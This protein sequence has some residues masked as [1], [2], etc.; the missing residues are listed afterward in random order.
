MAKRNIAEEIA[1]R[2]GYKEQYATGPAIDTI[3]KAYQNDPKTRLA[4]TALGR[5][6]DT[7]PVAEGGWGYSDG[8]ARVL[9]GVAGGAMTNAQN[10]RYGQVQQ[11]ELKDR[12]AADAEAQANLAAAVKKGGIP[13]PPQPA[14]VHQPMQP[15][16]A[17]PV[18]PAQALPQ[19]GAMPPQAPQM[20]PQGNQVDAVATELM[21]GG[22]LPAPPQAGQGGMQMP[23]PPFPAKGRGGSASLFDL[24]PGR[25]ALEAGNGVNI[26]SDYRT[27]KENDALPNSVKNS[28]HTR[29]DPEHPQAYDFTPRKGESMRVLELRAKRA[30]PGW[31]V[32]NEGNHIHVEPSRAMEAALKASGAATDQA[33]NAGA[34]GTATMDTQGNAVPPPPES[35]PSDEGDMPGLPAPIARPN[36]PKPV[37]ARRSELLE[38]AR[39]LMRTR[40]PWSADRAAAMLES[41]LAEQGRFNESAAER[42]QRMA[43]GIYNKDFDMYSQS[44]MLGRGAIYDERSQRRGF[45]HDTSERLGGE[46]FQAGESALERAQR[47]RE[48]QLGFG[49]DRDMAGV[50]F[51]YDTKR[52][53]Q[54]FE[55][56]KILKMLELDGDGAKSF[57]DFIN[58][59]AGSKVYEQAGAD[60]KD[61]SQGL[62]LLK[63]WEDLSVNTGGVLAATAPNVAAWGSTKMQVARQITNAIALARSKD[64]KGSLSDNDIKFLE[65]MSPNIRNSNQANQ[66]QIDQLRTVFARQQEFAIQK[67]RARS[68]KD[69]TQF[70]ENWVEYT[71]TFPE[72]KKGV[73]SYREWMAN[74][75]KNVVAV[76]NEDGSIKQ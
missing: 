69:P 37:G 55:H 52:A 24:T 45:G 7:S 3:A 58:T 65:K 76:Y 4:V 5:G 6:A 50:N 25:R 16:P 62:G 39:A 56:Q 12:E 21:G 28:Y 22:G 9:S 46:K 51:G 42:E 11:K 23:Q 18:A 30:F 63:Q 75:K 66:A 70:L 67:L 57:N 33:T 53:D 49:H 61:A 54:D 14:P 10:N 48:Q 27:Q 40:S 47:L 1:R 74:G 71:N 20:A 2:L 68:D 8:I 38:G 13:A 60:I 15:A 26:T 31:D 73:P 36:A 59:S 34:V 43:E 44:E 32:L 64:M 29:G 72:A 41:G 17:A 19:P 35:V